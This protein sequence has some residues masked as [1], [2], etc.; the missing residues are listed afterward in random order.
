MDINHCVIKNLEQFKE[1]NLLE[2]ERNLVED[3]SFLASIDESY[4]DY[5]PGNEYICKIN[6]ED[7]RNGNHVHPNI[8]G[9]DS[10]LRMHD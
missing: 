6:I 3:E 4:S 7:I 8:N 10:I 1:G 9:R 5:N 2:N